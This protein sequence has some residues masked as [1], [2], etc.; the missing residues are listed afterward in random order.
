MP[1]LAEIADVSGEVPKDIDGISIL[2]TLLGKGVQKQIPEY[3]WAGSMVFVL[4]ALGS[5]S[6]I[7]K[8]GHLYLYDLFKTEPRKTTYP[9]STLRLRPDSG[10]TLSKA[11]ANLA[12]RRMTESTPESELVKGSPPFLKRVA[13]CRFFRAWL[14]LR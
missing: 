12:V 14:L 10:S 1:T 9:P 3:M 11:T 13:P 4:C 7:G 8:G 2:P 6:G 5:G